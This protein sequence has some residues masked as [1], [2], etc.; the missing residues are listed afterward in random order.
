M[1][2]SSK[3]SNLLGAGSNQKGGEGKNS[4]DHDGGL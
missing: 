1:S 3:S 4:R 2:L